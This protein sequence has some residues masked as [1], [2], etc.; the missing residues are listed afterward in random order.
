MVLSI[1][2]Q[3]TYLTDILKGVILMVVDCIAVYCVSGLIRRRE[4]ATAHVP[5]EFLV[6]CVSSLVCYSFCHCILVA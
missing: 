3:P 6:S 4:H 1:I 2:S 5:T